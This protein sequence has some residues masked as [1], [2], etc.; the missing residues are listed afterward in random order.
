M[1][2]GIDK[3]A[4]PAKQTKPTKPSKSAK[5][6]RKSKTCTRR[7]KCGYHKFI[8][9][10]GKQCVEI[11]YIGRGSYG[12]VISPPIVDETY[13]AKTIIPYSEKHNND[14]AKLFFRDDAFNEELKFS[15]LIRKIDP[16]NKFTVK[17]KGAHKISGEC[18]RLSESIMYFLKR[19]IKDI[20]NAKFHQLIMENGGISLNSHISYS[21]SYMDFLQIFKEFI[22]DMI[23]IQQNN[24]IHRDI[25]P[26]NVLI[27]IE[28]KKINLID[29]GL[30]CQHYNELYDGKEENMS[31][32]KAAIEY[33]YYP[34]EF[35]VGYIM[36]KYRFLYENNKTALNKFVDTIYDKMEEKGFFAQ[37]KLRVDYNLK[38]EYQS[39]VK[40]FLQTIKSSGHIKCS[41]IFTR[42]VAMKADVFS[43]ASLIVSMS[44]KIRYTKSGQKHFIDYIYQKCVRANPYERVSFTELYSIINSEQLRSSSQS[45]LKYTDNRNI[46]IMHSTRRYNTQHRYGLAQYHGGSHFSSLKSKFSTVKSKL[47]TVKSKLSSIKDKIFPFMTLTVAKMRNIFNRDYK[48]PEKIKGSSRSRHS[49]TYSKHKTSTTMSRV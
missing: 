16:R 45:N 35:Y 4:K 11:K 12:C 17:I 31:L 26:H 48:S 20:Q 38:Q 24:V 13:I 25:K 10:D 19:K 21:L 29:F 6:S 36:L 14:V 27:D 44:S 7:P 15:K 3:A 42:D 40:S 46:P 49:L 33:P 9:P 5:A 23:T 18:I 37:E 1:T 41:E 43:V 34:P 2:G 22:G 28:K 30:I 47:L 32:L 39:G 8:T